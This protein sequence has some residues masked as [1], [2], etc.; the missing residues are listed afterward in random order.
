MT[1]LRALTPHAAIPAEQATRDSRQRRLLRTFLPEMVKLERTLAEAPGWVSTQV[2]ERVALKD[3]TVPIYRADLGS[4]SPNVPAFLLVGGVHGLE[5]IGSQVVIAWLRNLLSRLKWDQHL[6][7]L[8]EKVHITV[9]P[10]LNPGG[11]YLN[12]RSNPNGVDLMRNAPITAQD[13]SAFLLGGQRLS[14]RL[15]WYIGDPEQGMEPE[16]RALEGV[17]NSLLPGR[18]FSL[19]LDC[20][21]GFGWQDQIWFPYAYRRRPMRRIASVMALKVIWEQAYPNHDYRFEPQSRHYLTHGDLWD[22]FYKQVNRHSEGAFIPLTLEMGSWR[23]IRKR[24]RQLLRLDGLFNPLV[25][26]RHQ[27]V[28]RSHLPLLDF[29]ASAAASHDHWLPVSEEASMLREAAIMHWYRDNR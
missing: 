22:Y 3:V 18:P 7:E 28:L 4:D 14:P 8:L 9:L 11:M 6:R 1:E 23:W 17:I 24:P 26:H 13:R 10:I 19:A 5:R 12:Q 27:R 25:P 29:L 15:P 21:S 20:H 2:V 16:N